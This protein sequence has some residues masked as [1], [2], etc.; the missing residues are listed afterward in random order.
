MLQVLRSV[1]YV[2]TSCCHLIDAQTIILSTT[3]YFVIT[4]YKNIVVSQFFGSFIHTYYIG[5]EPMGIFQH[6]VSIPY[7]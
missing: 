5:L 1:W 7:H 6:V 4:A 3:E 2:K